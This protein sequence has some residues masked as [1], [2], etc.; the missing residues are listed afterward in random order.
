METEKKKFKSSRIRKQ[1]AIN[2]AMRKLALGLDSD[3]V[4]EII[5]ENYGYQPTSVINILATARR[6]LMNSFKRDTEVIKEECYQQLK[7]IADE[8]VDNNNYKDGIKALD[9]INK[10]TGAYDQTITI[11]QDE[12]FQIKFDN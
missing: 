6:R 3:E 11:K 10:M 12:P 7:T 9:L 2:C 4:T 1:S 5:C 8:A